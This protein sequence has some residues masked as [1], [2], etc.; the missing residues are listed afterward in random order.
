MDNNVFLLIAV[1]ALSFY[2]S[3]VI[4]QIRY[5]ESSYEDKIAKFGFLGFMAIAVATLVGG[6]IYGVIKTIGG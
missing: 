4:F 2:V 5:I 1:A 6:F 3:G